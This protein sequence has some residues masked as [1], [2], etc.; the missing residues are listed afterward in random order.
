MPV[1]RGCAPR[2]RPRRSRRWMPTPPRA[3]RRGTPS[4]RRTPRSAR[5]R[6]IR[7]LPAGHRAYLWF[8]Q[9]RNLEIGPVSH[10]FFDAGTVEVADASLGQAPRPAEN[11]TWVSGPRGA[12]SQRFGTPAGGR[13]AFGSDS[14]G[15][16]ASRL[17]LKKY[18]GHSVSPQF[19]MNADNTNAGLGWYLDD[20]RVYPCGHGPVPTVGPSVQGT[21][22][23]GSTLTADPGQWSS[24]TTTIR[25]YAGGVPIAG[26]TGTSYVLEQTDLGKRISVRV[27]ATANGR[28]AST[29]SV[30][31]A[32]VTS[33]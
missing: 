17:A 10:A 18:A 28:H 33:T 2:S 16:L 14:R 12:I 22:T 26:A 9:W 15:Y 1:P 30:A 27:T 5:W 13:I 3:A 7:A 32:P 24:G 20:I 31:T 11:R 4:T 8:Q 23:E 29:F 19:T 6:C 21:P 25:W